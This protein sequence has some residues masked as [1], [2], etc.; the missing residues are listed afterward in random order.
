MIVGDGTTDPA[1]ES[2]ATLRT[3]IGVGTGDAVTFGAITGTTASA[4]STTIALPEYI[5]I[6]NFLGAFLVFREETSR[7]GDDWYIITD[8]YSKDRQYDF[9]YNQ[10]TNTIKLD[11]AESAVQAREFRLT[12]FYKG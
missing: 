1:I 11:A 9:I 6:G 10:D 12:V 8:F 4:S 5:N 7:A 3:S 2:G